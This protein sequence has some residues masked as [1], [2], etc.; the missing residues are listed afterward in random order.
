[1]FFLLFWWYQYK[2]PIF[3][4]CIL[5]W[6]KSYSY[7]IQGVVWCQHV[8][9]SIWTILVLTYLFR[10]PC[11]Y[12]E[13]RLYLS[14]RNS[15]CNAHSTSCSFLKGTW[16]CSFPGIVKNTY[17]IHA[18]VWIQWHEIWLYFSLF[19]VDLLYACLHECFMFN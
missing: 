1:M 15:L 18:N 7:N 4:L 17:I 12:F 10:T 5:R 2:I 19:G 16:I 13:Y 3:S 14:N 8:L 11:L 6:N 9:G